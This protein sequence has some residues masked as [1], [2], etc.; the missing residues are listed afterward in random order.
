METVII[1]A[2]PLTQQSVQDRCGV[3]S[4]LTRLVQRRI[5]TA[6]FLTERLRI[7]APQQMSHR[8]LDRNGLIALLLLLLAATCLYVVTLD[9]GLSTGDLVGGDL[10]THQYAQVQAR[11]SNAPGYPLYTMGGWLW[12][13]GLRLLAP[14]ANPIPILSS[15]STIWALASLALFFLLLYKLTEKNVV[16]SFGLSVFYAITYF[17]WFYSVTT[18]QYTSAVLLTLAMLALALAWDQNPLDRYLYGIALLFGVSLAH[19]VTILF[20]APGILLFI[21]T[22]QPKLIT[23]Y[24]LI[25]GSLVIGLTPLLSYA[26]IY[27][28]GAQHPEWRGQGDWPSAWSWF[29]AFV[30]TQQGRD[31]LT[32]ALGSFTAEF[33]RLIWEEVSIVLLLVGIAGWFLKGRRYALLFGITAIIYFV[34]S[35]IDRF[36]N[37][38]QVIMP[39][40]PLVL[41]GAGISL[42]R[43][44]RAY[45]AR[46]WR[47]ALTGLL[48]ALI[49]LKF[50]DAYPRANQRNRADDTGLEPGQVILAGNPPANAAIISSVEEKLALDYLTGIWGQ[51]PD[52]RAITTRQA[53]SA[54]AAGSPLLVTTSAA[55]YAAEEIGTSLRYS[56]WSPDLLLAKT[57][58]LPQSLPAGLAET[59]QTLGDQLDLVGWL[60]APARDEAVWQAWVALRANASPS[61]DWALSV[62]LLQ[63]GAEIAQQ[64]HVAPA[65]GNTPTS[66]LNPSE[67]VLDAFRFE[68]PPGSQPDGVRLILYRQLVDGA[69]E[70]LAVIDLD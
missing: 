49:I 61:A 39:M 17:F 6:I 14:N 12:F 70:N 57:D 68:P 7:L 18:E 58:R 19:M 53:D 47:V 31:E 10:I 54:L 1:L 64:D 33:P 20:V 25:A 24:K 11:P 42:A 63:D 36:G 46:L 56:S 45:P 30:S 48:L 26:Y 32:W 21:L 67:I 50:A 40:Y 37:W 38:Y 51:R 59:D 28:R 55:T 3:L 35:Y 41:L 60:L 4:A 8:L 29:L 69:F 52:V 66:S 5:L 43:L 16:I 34:F 23:R 22:K 44:W 27:L 65:A 9:N 2:H 62:R 13:H 15:Y